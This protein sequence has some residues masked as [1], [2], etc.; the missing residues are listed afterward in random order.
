MAKKVLRGSNSLIHSKKQYIFY[1]ILGITFVKIIIIFNIDP[2]S[3]YYKAGAW[4]G[5]DTDGYLQGANAIKSEGFFTKS[6]FLS[7]Y[8]PGYPVFLYVIQKIF[9]SYLI[10]VV[11]ILQ[12]LFYS[13]SIY[14]VAKQLLNSGLQ[15]FATTFT[16]IALLNPTLSL[17]T[18][19]LG[20][21]GLVASICAIVLGLFIKS[22]SNLDIKFISF[23]V[24]TAATLMGISIW[25]APRMILAAFM[26]V[27]FWAFFMKSKSRLL[28][29]FM[30]ILI[31]V[32]FQSSIVMR[33]YIAN[34]E[35]SSQT[36][37]GNLALMG[38]GP[39][40]TGT[41]MNSPSGIYCKT[42][43]KEVSNQSNQR[44]SCAINWYI[45][46]PLNGAKLLWKKSYYLW[47]PWY[48][49][50]TGGT[51]AANPYYRWFHPIKSNITT[52]SQLDIVTG[53]PGKIVSWFW[54]VGG[55]ILLIIGFRYLFSNG[56]MPN[57]VG[58]V[59]AVLILSNWITALITIGDNRYRIPL[60]TI[61]LL[62]Q[63]IGWKNLIDKLQGR[64]S[65][66]DFGGRLK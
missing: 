16:F 39:L 13:F 14:F 37:L 35:Y 9:G 61:S 64:S 29:G 21:E 4:V 19:Q 26:L 53:L 50:L 41:Y 65:S 34:G 42:T 3:D 59:S 2:I 25:L 6:D 23:E 51:S 31:I 28:S 22:M 57:K 33:N 10:L 52:Q 36:S 1:F 45:E 66:N 30:A 24:L 38:A 5:S 32:G 56:G 7:Y 11:S 62:V 20:Y 18:M 60:M 8:A 27:I 48:G 55:W 44:L 43:S 12:T 49:P 15:L 46:N 17:S 58:T 47:S 54:I 63:V 40:A